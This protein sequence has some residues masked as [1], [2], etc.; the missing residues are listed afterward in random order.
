MP[1][2]IDPHCHL[3]LPFMGTTA[4]DDFDVGTKAAVAGGT[5]TFIDFIIPDEKGLLHGYNDWRARADKKVHCD[6]ALHCAITDWNEQ[7]SKD[8]EEMVKRGVQSFK[9]FTAYK[10]S[11][12]YQTDDR[13]LQIF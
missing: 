3:E 9:L 13:M 10:G 8:M 1:G 4:I 6:Y 12:F 2:G 7:V 11:A 5:T